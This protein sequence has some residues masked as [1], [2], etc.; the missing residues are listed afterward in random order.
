V[1]TFAALRRGRRKYELRHYCKDISLLPGYR[2][3]DEVRYAFT[4]LEPEYHQM[5]NLINAVSKHL[6]AS[7]KISGRINQP[8]LSAVIGRDTFI[9]FRANVWKRQKV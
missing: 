8:T 9:S 2:S 3:A 1:E 4:A 6:P 5:S 7:L